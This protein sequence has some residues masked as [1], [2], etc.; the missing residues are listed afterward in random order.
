MNPTSIFSAIP[1]RSSRAWCPARSPVGHA[2]D[3][4]LP[5]NHW[6]AAVVKAAS[7][8]VMT[9]SFLEQCCFPP[10]YSLA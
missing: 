1:L 4:P 2:N 6:Q 7:Q 3:W 9:T 10:T 8:V 5:V